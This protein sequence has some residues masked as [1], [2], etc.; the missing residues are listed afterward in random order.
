MALARKLRSTM[1]LPEI[2]LWQRLQHSDVKFRRQHP[3]GRYVLDFYCAA[4]WICVEVDGISHDMGN[5]PSR[6][7]DRDAWLNAQ[8]VSVLR[9][10][11]A[12]VLR[13]PDGVA[14]GIVRAVA[15]G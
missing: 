11:A 3:V 12:D 2:L 1:S 6:D 5:N 9:I 8:G 10:C 4:A 15:G 13:D 14:D 7:T